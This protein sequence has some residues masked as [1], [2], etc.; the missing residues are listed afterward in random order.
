[1]GLVCI[2]LPS[3]EKVGDAVDQKGHRP[4]CWSGTMYFAEE[5]PTVLLGITACSSY[6]SCFGGRRKLEVVW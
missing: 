1:M 4:L 2:P 6:N 3:R 5:Q